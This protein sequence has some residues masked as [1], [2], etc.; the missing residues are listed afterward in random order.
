MPV[1]AEH[2]REGDLL[3]LTLPA[4][5]DSVGR[6]MTALYLE[7]LVLGHRPRVVRLC[8]PP[9]RPSPASLGVVARL[10]R[11]CEAHGISLWLT[12]RHTTAPDADVTT[13]RR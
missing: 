5:F 1:P 2:S 4:D 13:R 8:M 6:A 12:G 7:N 3:S 11:L 10:H 9:G